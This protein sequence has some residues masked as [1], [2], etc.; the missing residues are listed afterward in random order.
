[1]GNTFFNRA[2]KNSAALNLPNHGAM[3][4]FLCQANG[5][6]VFKI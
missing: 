6:L 4:Y 1:M 5:G 2:V 3:Q